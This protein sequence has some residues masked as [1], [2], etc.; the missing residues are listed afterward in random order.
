VE[1][2]NKCP[3]KETDEVA[4]EPVISPLPESCLRPDSVEED[5]R[6]EYDVSY[7]ND[8]FIFGPY[9]RPFWERIDDNRW[10]Y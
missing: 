8:A 5:E 2:Q 9:D 7:W 3:V 4:E 10:D 1:P 6:A